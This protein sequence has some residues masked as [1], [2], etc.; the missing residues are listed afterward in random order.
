MRDFV[1]RNSNIFSQE[2]INRYLELKNNKTYQA[3]KRGRDFQKKQMERRAKEAEYYPP[4]Q[5]GF[6]A[7][8]THTF[9]GDSEDEGSSLDYQA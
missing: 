5:V 9:L 8:F 6:G 1:N 7:S 4:P 2:A 3:A